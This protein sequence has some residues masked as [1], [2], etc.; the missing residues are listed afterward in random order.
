VSFL[1]LKFITGS[2]EKKKYIQ[3]SALR[4]RKKTEE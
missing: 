1:V 3:P 4:T 2:G